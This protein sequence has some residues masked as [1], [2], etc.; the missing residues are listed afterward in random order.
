[1]RHTFFSLSAC[2]ALLAMTSTTSAQ[3][4]TVERIFA[5]PDLSGPRLQDPKFSPDGRYVTY[6]Q[7][8][9]SNKDQLDLWAFDTRSGKADL[10]VDSAAFASSSEQLSAAEEARRERQRTAAL[11]G[12]VEY[13]FS[14]DGKKLLVPLAGDLYVYDLTARHAAVRR[15]THTTSYETDARFSPRGNYVSFIR[16]QNLFIIKV[17]GSNER[18]LTTDGAG[19]IQNGVAE[20]VAQEEMDRNTGYWWAP[21]EKRIAFTR[22]DDSPV[23]EVERLEINADSAQI[24]HQRYPAA[25]TANTRVELKIIELASNRIVTVDLGMDDRYLARVNWFPDAAHLAVQRQSRDQRRLDLLKVS[26]ESGIASTLL[27][28]TSSSWVELNDDLRFLKKRSAFIW[29]S[30]RT[31]FKHLYLYDLDGTLIRPLTAGDWMVVGDG[32]ADGL[33]GIDEKIGLAYFLANKESPLERQFYSTSLDTR[34]AADVRRISRETGWH[35]A[36]LLPGNSS[37]LDQWSSPEQPPAAVIRNLDGKAL[38]WLVRNQLDQA[39]PYQRFMADHV[40][41]EFGS[42]KSADGQDLYYRLLKPAHIEPGKRYPVVVDTYGGPGFQYVR[43]DWMG[44]ARAAQGYFRQVL[45]QHGYVVFSL[46]NR[47]SGFRGDRFESAIKDRLGKVEVADQVHGVEFLR[48]QPYVDPERIGVM[49]WSYGGYMTLLCLTTTTAFRAGVAGAPVT[50]W[51]L[52]DTHYTERYLGDPTVNANGYAA[53]A[54]MPYS[55]SLR[56]NLLLVH[57]MADDNV[58]F[59]HSTRLMQQLQMLNQPFDVMTYPGG[60]HGLIRMP[61][62]GR[63]YYEMVLRFFDDKL[64]R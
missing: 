21:D 23:Q 30:R 58:L 53:S 55:K 10:L 51:S 33:V 59:T 64:K 27:T 12:I 41:E 40:K 4:L 61:Q 19:L 22:I 54:V 31:G 62:T 18:A 47:G 44:G 56:G 50:D 3:P 34:N 6:L 37:Y 14:A 8:K 24:S 26:A 15:L 25:G 45:A 16:D 2:L 5:A 63:H 11:R 20:F 9:E 28:E 17:D 52:Y 42:I 46:D 48:E 7:G 39:Q 49:G 57:G 38:H 60:K 36:K 1:M 29:S 35:N 43:K 13:Q 32:V